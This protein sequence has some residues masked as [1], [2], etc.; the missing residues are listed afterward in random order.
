MPDDAQNIDPTKPSAEGA[1]RDHAAAVTPPPR[2][3]RPVPIRRP[4]PPHTIAGLATSASIAVIATSSSVAKFDLAELG[5]ADLAA[6]VT[7]LAQGYNLDV[8]MPL[9]SVLVSAAT[10]LGSLVRIEIGGAWIEAPV[11]WGMMVAPPGSRKTAMAALPKSLLGTI[12]EDEKT[13]W[14]QRREAAARE[15]RK[16]EIEW[17]IYDADCRRAVRK[18]FPYPEPPARRPDAVV[19]PI[20]PGIV[21]ED[22]TIEEITER[23]AGS[24]R[25]ILAVS[26]E[27]STMLARGRNTRALM[28][29]ATSAGSLR[30]GR[31][32]RESRELTSFSVSVLTGT[33]PDRVA[34]F[35][36]GEDDGLAARFLWVWVSETPSPRIARVPLKLDRLLEVIARLR[37]MGKGEELVVIPMSEEGIDRLE[38]AMGVWR[39]EGRKRGGL[40]QSWYEKAPGHA[41][42]LALV[43]EVLVQARA[44]EKLPTVISVARIEAAISL[45]DRLFAPAMAMVAMHIGQDRGER[46]R[47][48]LI[49]HLGNNH[50]ERFRARDLRR[51]HTRLFGTPGQFEDALRA[52]EADGVLSRADR[53]PGAQGRSPGDYLVNRAKLPAAIVS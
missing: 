5:D 39:A 52:L 40:V 28:L 22:S 47:S 21:I 41:S 30:V 35:I 1:P 43:L 12:A 7:A 14:I 16:L 50:V 13:E 34:G 19:V 31:I 32:S 10:A 4:Q 20:R 25:G 17:S 15:K 27:A 18:D 8:G 42:R 9:V 48:N 45:I 44:G 49:Q 46:I 23:L 24:P 37:A 26:D 3:P 29:Q 6:D 33:Q 36:G 51:T 2:L 11:L 38:R 53:Q